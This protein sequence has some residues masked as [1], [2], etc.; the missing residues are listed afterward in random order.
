MVF[1]LVPTRVA[2]AMPALEELKSKAAPEAAPPGGVRA[3]SQAPSGSAQ[4]PAGGE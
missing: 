1:K 2:V 3:P 4:S